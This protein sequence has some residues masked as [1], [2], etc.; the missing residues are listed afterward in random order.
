MN[1]EH[2][3]PT[4]RTVSY[5][6][7]RRLRT[8]LHSVSIAMLILT[9]TL[10]VFIYRQT[11]LIRNSTNQLS[12]FVD[13]YQ[14]GNEPDVLEK[15][16]QRLDTYRQQDPAFNPIFLKYFGTNSS[17]LNLRPNSGTGSST[18]SPAR[19]N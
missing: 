12:R 1:P 19:T 4:N 13:D 14:Q 10:F 3:I 11:V 7:W 17:P 16:R 5:E 2:E 6:D 8:L 15:V 18:K 9:G